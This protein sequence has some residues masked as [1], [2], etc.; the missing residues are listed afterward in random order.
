MQNIQEQ[1]EKTYYFAVAY[2]DN[3]EASVSGAF[4]D[5]CKMMEAL[6]K[7]TA[8][9]AHK[10]IATTYMTRKCTHVPSTMELFGHPRSRDIMKDRKFL[11]SL[12]K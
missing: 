1:E 12:T 7:A 8:K 4:D 9:N 2:F 11:A 3:G 5:Q 6:K 10:V